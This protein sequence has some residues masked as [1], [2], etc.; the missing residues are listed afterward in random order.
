[1]A[2]SFQS[3]FYDVTSVSIYAITCLLYVYIK[4]IIDT[5]FLI[6]YF[7]AVHYLLLYLLVCIFQWQHTDWAEKGEVWGNVLE[8]EV[9]GLAE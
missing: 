9:W 6:K 7:P 4:H 5:F 3:F 1:M 2:L 8:G